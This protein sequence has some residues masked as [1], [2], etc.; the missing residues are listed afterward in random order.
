[1]ATVKTY[2]VKCYELA[3]SFLSDTSDLNHEK[4]R[5][6]LALEIQQVIED[7]IE[8]MREGIFNANTAECDF[9]RGSGRVNAVP[10]SSAGQTRG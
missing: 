4:A 9:C 2:D 3:S 1:M 8:F 7:E 6:S 10:V 5:H